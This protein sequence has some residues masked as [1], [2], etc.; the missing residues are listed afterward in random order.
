MRTRIAT[1]EEFRQYQAACMAAREAQKRRVLVCCGTGCVAGG[2][3]KVAAVG[4]YAG[5]S[6]ETGLLVDKIVGLDG[7]H[8]FLFAHVKEGAK[9]DVTRAG[10]H[11]DA[12]IRGKAHGG[13]D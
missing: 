4:G 2:S 8:A 1:L 3:L 5:N 9:V 10:S 6:L 12:C 7:A 11:D 13:V